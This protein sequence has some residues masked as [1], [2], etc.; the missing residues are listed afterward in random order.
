MVAVI[1]FVQVVHYPLFASVG[2]AAFARYERQHTRRITP[3]V[4]PLMLA[5]L[6]SGALVVAALPSWTTPLE[7]WLGAGLI[8][9]VWLSTGLLQ[10]PAHGRLAEGFDEVWHRRLVRSNWLRTVAWSARGVLVCLWL[11]RA[12]AQ[13]SAA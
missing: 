4:A 12:L 8:A 9:L 13:T 11:S 10:V 3:I 6:G 5:E 1:W 7:A 2:R